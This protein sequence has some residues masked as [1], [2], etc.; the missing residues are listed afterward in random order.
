MLEF[1]AHA[2]SRKPLLR[3]TEDA[4]GGHGIPGKVFNEPELI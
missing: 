4:N 3:V 1:A 2:K